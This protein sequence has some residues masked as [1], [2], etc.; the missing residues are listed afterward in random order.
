[1]RVLHVIGAMDCA[2]AETFLMNLYRNIDR[3]KIQFDF[4]VHTEKH[5]FFEEEI[6][7]LGGK[8]YRAPRFNG[9]NLME[10]RAWWKN[11]YKS[12][13]EYKIIH[14]HVGSTSSIYLSLGNKYNR[15]TIAH[16]HN[17]M[18]KGFSI[19]NIEY[20]ILTYRNR[21]IA[22][23]FMGCSK[24]AGI[25]RYGKKIANSS[26]FMVIMNGIDSLR[27]VYSESTRNRI[28]EI[29]DIEGDTVIVGHVGR[30]T[31]QKNHEK[32]I[33]VFNSYHHKN[34]NSVLWLFGVGELENQ[35]KDKVDRLGLN[36]VVFFKG[37][38]NEINNEMQAMDVFLFPS[39]FEG[40]GIA[41]IEAQ[42]TGLPCVVSN[43]I[44]DE[45]DIKAGLVK[46]LDLSL[47]NDD[48]S[49]AIEEMIQMKRIDTSDYVKK[50]GFDIK[51]V[52]KSLQDFY[53]DTWRKKYGK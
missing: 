53:L 29:N 41:L 3:N 6:L 28:R 12:H 2:G 26:R 16:S 4:V 27:Y 21:Y 8:I 30:F 32:V 39:I 48:W 10:Y 5:M 44:Q 43:V 31:Q 37:L 50:A 23:F 47:S 34:T 49:S 35:I 7:G 17:T 51:A 33:D 52:A 22:D 13:P 42:A 36:N 14:G 9:L 15:Y 18:N 19:G 1:M 25:D 38:S 40:L 11:F 45:A 24:Q 20:R 46:K